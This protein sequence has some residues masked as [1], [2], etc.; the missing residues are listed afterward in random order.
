MQNRLEFLHARILVEKI[1]K[2][3]YSVKL[4]SDWL[5]FEQTER[6]AIAAAFNIH[7]ANM[8]FGVSKRGLQN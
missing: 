5:T 8:G 4:P 7:Y 1:I 3:V 2:I 6:H